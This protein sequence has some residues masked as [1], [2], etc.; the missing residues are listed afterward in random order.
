[1][2]V[3][4]GDASSNMNTMNDESLMVNL[5]PVAPEQTGKGLPYAPENWPEEGDIWGW[6]TGKRV[7]VTT[8]FF[9]DRYLYPPTRLGRPLRVK[10][11]FPSK[12]SVERYIKDNFPHLD[13]NHFFAS[14]SW[15]IPALLN[16]NEELI[17]AVP[18]QNFKQESESFDSVVCKA[19]NQCCSSLNFEKKKYPSA[20]PCDICCV[21]PGFCRD[22]CCILC[23][24]TVDSAFDDYSYIK[25]EVK[26]G[27][28]ICGHIAHM[29]CALRA[30][31]AGTIGGSIGLDAEYYCRRCDGRTD[32][33]SHVN[34][35]AQI[36]ESIDLD[37]DIEEKILHLCICLLRDSQKASAKELVSHLELSISKGETVPEDDDDSYSPTPQSAGFSDNSDAANDVTTVN[38]RTDVRTRLESFGPLSDSLKLEVEVDEVLK[39]LRKSQQFEYNL[40]EE[41]LYAH[42]NYL[43]NLYQQLEYEESELASKKHSSRSVAVI[44][45]RKVQ[46][47]KEVMKFE[48][49]KRVANGFGKTSKDILKD[50]FGL[51]IAD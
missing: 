25:C 12:L 40:A 39:A 21:E 3:Q 22:C 36:C 48:D 51:E 23:C 35:V 1:M 20:M 15:K 42:K 45:K 18:I 13:L 34:K 5:T 32:M 9:N 44:S 26:F 7:S 17:A 28:D 30:R 10:P 50:N 49:M 11:G 47:R 46:I 14:F 2:E 27:D 4:N 43:Q 24:K 33:I 41:R 37:Y 29:E 19:G 6:R 8:G 16:G 31:M 38:E